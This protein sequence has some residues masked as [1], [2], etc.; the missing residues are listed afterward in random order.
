MA[1]RDR[2]SGNEA[3]AIAMRQI[4]PDVFPAFPITPSTEIPQFFSQYVADGKV[5]TEFITVE[6][7]HSAMSACIGAQSAGARSMTATSSAGFA[8]MWE[9]LYVAASCRL[10]ITLA[11]VNRAL[12]G[13]IN[14]NCDHSDAMGARDAGWIQI[15]SENN[16]EAYDNFIQ[17]VRIGE[18]ADVQLPVMVCQD[19]FITSHAV[20]NIELI[21]DEKV[22]AFVGEYEPEEYLLNAAQPIAV[23]PYD[24]SA[25]YIEH[26]RNQAEGMIKAKD[27][28]LQVAKE[29][30][31]MSGREYGLFEEY[32]LDDAE[33]VIV[34]IN[35]TAGTAKAAIDSLRKIGVKAGLLKI[36]VFRP[37]P[38]QEIAKALSGK[39]AVAVMDR[40]EGFSAAGG[41]LFAEIRSA[42]YDASDRPMAVNYIYGLGG[43]DVTT[44]DIEKVYSDLADMATSGEAGET[45]RYLGVRE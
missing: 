36:R 12:T 28:I 24:S 35:S 40:C 25:Y 20:E 2:L 15:Y 26:K 29:F 9:V 8:Y 3:V 6:S 19:G 32:R 31:D 43:R 30:K 23:G 27:V 18:H 39:K 16:Q 41:P 34:V 11:C 7:E 17:A 13:P 37:F 21:E 44:G 38:M 14:I 22:K 42:L 1:I 33:L 4:N 10:P 45:Y 5:A